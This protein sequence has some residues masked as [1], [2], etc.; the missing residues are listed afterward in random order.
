MG[1]RNQKKKRKPTAIFASAHHGVARGEPMYVI[2]DQS[3]VMMDMPR[4][5]E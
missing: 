4:P 1:A 3:N 2:C 5:L